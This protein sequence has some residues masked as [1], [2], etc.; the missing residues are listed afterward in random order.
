MLNEAEN[1]LLYSQHDM[2]E[3]HKIGAGRMSCKHT[4]WPFSADSNP[5]KCKRSEVNNGAYLILSAATKNLTPHS[6]INGVAI[7]ADNSQ[8]DQCSVTRECACERAQVRE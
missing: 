7:R 5:S 3:R 1:Q 2:P 6:S 4:G 8:C